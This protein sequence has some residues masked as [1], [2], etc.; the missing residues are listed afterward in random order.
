MNAFSDWR[1]LAEVDYG[2]I[3]LGE[4]RALEAAGEFDPPPA[5]EPY[6]PD[7][8]LARVA[9]AVASN[10][11]AW[12]ADAACRGVDTAIFFPDTRSP[13][14]YAY[15]EARQICAGCEVRTECLEHA[16]ASETRNFDTVGMWGGMTSKER[17]AL[18]RYRRNHAA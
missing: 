2:T 9:A 18:K 10:S 8:S 3:T 16:L 4:Y 7:E 12:M 11:P 13:N 14:A 15:I 5:P 1:S 6:N 17:K